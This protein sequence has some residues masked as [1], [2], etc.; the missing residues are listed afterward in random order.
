[1]DHHCPWVNNCIGFWNRKYFMLLLTY[2]HLSTY[3][4]AGLM[5]PRFLDTA[6]QFVDLYYSSDVRGSDLFIHG[7]MQVS[8]LFN[9]L[10]IILMTLFFKF[11]IYLV[12]SNKTTI[13]N[14]EKRDF[15]VRPYDKGPAQNF[16]QVFGANWLLWPFPIMLQAGK[17][18]GDGVNWM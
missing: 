13:D 12:I 9:L 18:E 11:H 1:M 15:D 6:F 7:L 5:L 16:R 17:P 2:V 8:Y 3:Y 14:L 10:L 4:Y